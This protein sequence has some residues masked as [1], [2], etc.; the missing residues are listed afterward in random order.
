MRVALAI[1]DVLPDWR[2]NV[3]KM[4]VMA[5]HAAAS[6]AMAI[7]FS[8]AAVTGFVNTGTP[9]FDITPGH[10]CALAHRCSGWLAAGRRMAMR[11]VVCRIKIR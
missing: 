8:E 6:N 10:G 2:A 11:R 3:E 4:C 9:A 5:T 7:F 1:P